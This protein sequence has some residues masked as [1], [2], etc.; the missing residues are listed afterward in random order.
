MYV[1][2]TF[3]HSTYLELALVAL[4]TEEIPGENILA[5]PL[6]TRTGTRRVFDSIHHSDGIS[7]ID[8]GASLATAFSVIGASVGFQL[9]WGPIIWGIIGA[10]VGFILGFLLD[11]IFNSKKRNK[12][13]GSKGKPPK[14]IL[15]IHCRKEQVK[16]VEEILWSNLALGVAKLDLPQQA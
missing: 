5:I 16:A 1:M 12:L 15:I 6:E 10:I 9:T 8:L 14:I 7:L 2:S 4:E 11:L 13:S 3:E